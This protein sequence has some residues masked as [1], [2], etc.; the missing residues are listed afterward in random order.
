VGDEHEGLFL[1]PVQPDEEVHDLL[2]GLGV[3]GSGRL[4]GPDDGGRVH[5]RPG[6]GDPLLLPAAHLGRALAGLVCEADHPEGV[7]GEPAGLLRLGARDQ[8][9]QLHVLDGREH[10]D[11][12][13]GLEDKAHLVRPEAGPL[14][15][16]HL[17]YRVARDED[18]PP[19]HVVQPGHAVQERRLP[20]P[21]RPHD[22]DHLPATD[23]EVHALE[24]VDP[25]ATGGVDLLHAGGLDHQ[26]PRG[27]LHQTSSSLHRNGLSLLEHDPLL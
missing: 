23:A 19:V 4:V 5:Q 22:G 9:W 20:A 2:A 25:Q 16:G 11:Q 1:L 7:H 13:V 24:R 14:P 17:A 26:L 21:G 12:V 10:R 8:Q 18:L 6:D 15:V 27:I 3:E